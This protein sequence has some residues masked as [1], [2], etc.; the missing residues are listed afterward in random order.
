MSGARCREHLLRKCATHGVE[1]RE[2]LVTK[3]TPPPA[4]PPGPL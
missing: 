3:V 2:T 4:L 1:V